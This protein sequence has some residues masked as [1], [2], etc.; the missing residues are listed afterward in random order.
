M[1]TSMAS[2]PLVGGLLSVYNLGLGESCSGGWVLFLACQQHVVWNIG[3]SS[4]GCCVR[5][6]CPLKTILL[7]SS[8]W[9]SKLLGRGE[10]STG[11]PRDDL[12]VLYVA[13]CIFV[14]ELR[15][16]ISL[17]VVRSWSVALHHS[18]D[19]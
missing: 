19:G 16:C 9:W 12:F 10:L 4:V 5:N 6:V 1:Y 13:L 14:V 18:H 15:D 8:F 2:F 7:G 3:T 17:D 11:A